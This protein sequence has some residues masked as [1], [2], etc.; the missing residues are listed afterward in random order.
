[1]APLLAE[2]PPA[3]DPA[4][5]PA[6]MSYGPWQMMFC[7]FAT[8]VQVSIVAGTAELADYAQEF[9]RFF[10]DYVIFSRRAQTLAEI[11][12]VWNEGHIA[13][14]PAYVAKLTAAYGLA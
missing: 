13:P 9:V 4:Q 6:A 11:G 14:D 10:N 8:A 1:M 2:Y 3:G 12:E 5:S 7:N